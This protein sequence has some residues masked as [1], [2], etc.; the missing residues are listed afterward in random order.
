LESN[1]GDYWE[2]KLT[3]RFAPPSS[4][5]N[6]IPVAAS[7]QL[8]REYIEEIRGI[9]EGCRDVGID[10]TFDELLAWNGYLDLMSWWPT[11]QATE[12]PTIGSSYRNRRRAGS[13]LANSS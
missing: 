4:W 11:K 5:Q 3:M 8:S 1:I 2:R 10:T 9:Y 13:R 7:E 12:N 6:G